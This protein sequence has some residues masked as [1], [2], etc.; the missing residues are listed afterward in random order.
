MS[1]NVVVLGGR[2][3]AQPELK[4]TASGLPV[5][6]IRLAV[7]R[8]AG[9]DKEKQTDFIQ[10]VL[11]RQTAEVA[12]KFV[13]KGDPITVTGSLQT[14]QYEDRG[15]HKRTAYEVIVDRLELPPKGQKEQGSKEPVVTV[16]LHEPDE[17]DLPF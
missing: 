2:V 13:K 1:I 10:L 16:Q 8:I 17:E 3:V 5:T 15:G 14:R 6:T 11:W 9:K 12:C 7:D 4:T